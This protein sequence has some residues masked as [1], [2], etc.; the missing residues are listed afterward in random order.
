MLIAQLTST[1]NQKIKRLNNLAR[2][3]KWRQKEKCLVIEGEKIVLNTMQSA[4]RLIDTVFISVPLLQKHHSFF[5]DYLRRHPCPVYTL[6]ESLFTAVS[7]LKHSSGLL[8]IAKQPEYDFLQLLPALANIVL[9]DGLQT[10]AN[11]GAIIRNAV[12]FNMDAILYTSGTADPFHPES[13]RAMAGHYYQRPIL[14]C[15]ESIFKTMITQEFTP[16]VLDAHSGTPLETS[17]FRKKNIF[18]L[19]SEGKGITTDFLASQEKNGYA[20][21]ISTSGQVES[22]N[23]AVASGITFHWFNALTKPGNI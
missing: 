18:I 3:T 2:Y 20:I 1:S 19:G 10:P 17:P 4:P 8:A 9:L 14:P 23:V 21:R 12:A 7:T 5:D 15:T 22:L 13:V 6:D 16:R 11:I